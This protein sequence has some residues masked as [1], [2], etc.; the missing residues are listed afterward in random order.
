MPKQP[1]Q[2]ADELE[3]L[4][5]IIHRNT[6]SDVEEAMFRFYRFCQVSGIPE[7]VRQGMIEML[8][9]RA[10]SRLELEKEE[11][12]MLQDISEGHIRSRY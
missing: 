12:D 3:N 9:E 11:A 10:R 1:K 7:R 8:S 6:V 2:L 5:F 4:R